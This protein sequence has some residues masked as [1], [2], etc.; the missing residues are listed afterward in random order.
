MQQLELGAVVNTTPALAIEALEP[1]DAT[2][3]RW[4]TASLEETKEPMWDV[5]TMSSSVIVNG[6][7]PKTIYSFRV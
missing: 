3:E 4:V 1:I 6:L 2:D 5:A 7:S